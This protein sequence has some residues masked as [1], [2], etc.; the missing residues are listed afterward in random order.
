[1]HDFS[2]YVTLTTTY[3]FVLG[4]NFFGW[5]GRILRKVESLMMILFSGSLNYLSPPSYGEIASILWSSRTDT[6]NKNF[7]ISCFLYTINGYLNTIIFYWILHNL[8]MLYNPFVKFFFELL[9]YFCMTTALWNIYH[10]AFPALFSLRFYLSATILLTEVFCLIFNIKENW[11]GDFPVFGFLSGSDLSYD[12]GILSVNYLG[13]VT[14]FAS[15]IVYT[16]A[17]CHIYHHICILS[18][19]FP[20]IYGHK[21]HCY[22]IISVLQY[23]P[24][25][26]SS[27]G[28]H[29][30]LYNDTFTFKLFNLK[31]C[32]HKFG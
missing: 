21:N 20:D 15:R 28:L 32:F 19:C 4:C 16:T 14:I 29:K 25:D 31:Y 13:V 8:S 7:G 23:Y 11:W 3:Y 1:M 9:I 12:N 2:R 10:N 27:F 22:L 26:F 5:F 18:W 17:D 30:N 24:Y 6:W